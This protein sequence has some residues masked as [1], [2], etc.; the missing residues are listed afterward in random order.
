MAANPIDSILPSSAEVTLLT[1]AQPLRFADGTLVPYT[2][3]KDGVASRNVACIDAYSEGLICPDPDRDVFA[4]AATPLAA[5]FPLKT[6]LHHGCKGFVDDQGRW[7]VEVD[8]AARSRVAYHAAREL[9]TG[10]KTGSKSFQ[11]ST[12]ATSTATSGALLPIAAIAAA[13]ADYE[14]CTQGAKAYIHVPSV[15]LGHL[16]IVGYFERRGDRLVTPEGHVLVPGPGYPNSAGAF[17]PFS[18]PEDPD[19]AAESADGEVFIYVT[20]EVE[21]PDPEYPGPLTAKE[22]WAVRQNEFLATARAVTIARFDPCC[23]F[24]ALT[25]IPGDN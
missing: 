6:N 9:W 11:N 15:L 3:W 12:T 8:A 13:L 10:A 1:S 2:T 17:G 14:E 23:V 5:F 19:T 22:E 25:T 18:D 20:G 24:A 7:R 16:S 4:P 21:A